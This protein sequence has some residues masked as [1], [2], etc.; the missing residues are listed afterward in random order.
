MSQ[1]Q[2][3]LKLQNTIFINEIFLVILNYWVT[4]TVKLNLEIPKLCAFN[5]RKV[6][7]Y[8]INKINNKE[9]KSIM[10]APASQNSIK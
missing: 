7:V 9:R 6:A 10:V 5:K 2:P 8:L 1:D 4:Y 3:E